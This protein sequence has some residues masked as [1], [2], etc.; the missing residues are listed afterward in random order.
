MI[1]FCMAERQNVSS[2]RVLYAP[3][4]GHVMKNK[5]AMSDELI[6]LLFNARA[7]KSWKKQRHCDAY[8]N[9]SSKSCLGIHNLAMD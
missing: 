9:C 6:I 8:N 2:Y 1:T 7:T 3:I 4:I 5:K